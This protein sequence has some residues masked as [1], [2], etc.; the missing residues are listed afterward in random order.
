MSQDARKDS[1]SGLL[2]AFQ[3]KL[4]ITFEENYPALSRLFQQTESG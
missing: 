4:E 3:D 1:L 2:E